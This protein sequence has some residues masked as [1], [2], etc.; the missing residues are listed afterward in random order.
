VSADA[1]GATVI[2]ALAAIGLARVL[3][4]A[5]LASL[6]SLR[7][8]GTRLARLGER[9]TQLTQADVDRAVAEALARVQAPKPRAKRQDETEVSGN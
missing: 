2:L 4:L 5:Y 9:P 6:R 7:A 3:R 1:I 8:L